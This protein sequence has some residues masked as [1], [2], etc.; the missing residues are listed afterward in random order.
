MPVSGWAILP[1]GGRGDLGE[2]QGRGSRYRRGRPLPGPAPSLRCLGAG[3]PWGL[4]V[5]RIFASDPAPSQWVL[6]CHFTDEETEAWRDATG[7]LQPTAPP[8]PRTWPPREP[9]C[10]SRAKDCSRSC[11]RSGRAVFREPLSPEPGASPL[12]LLAPSPPPGAAHRC[13]SIGCHFLA[14]PAGHTSPNHEA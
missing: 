11:P 10:G 4:C 1:K 9:Q 14:G 8:G 13:P 2:I 3:T 5:L 12:P 6:H 7:S